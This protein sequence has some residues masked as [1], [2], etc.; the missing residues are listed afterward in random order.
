MCANVMPRREKVADLLSQR[1]A[2]P[3][4]PSEHQ[5]LS[6]SH[7]FFTRSITLP[8]PNRLP[9]NRAEFQPVFAFSPTW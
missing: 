8:T 7:P 5:G 1:I 6:P 4:I 3:A 9:E 2:Q